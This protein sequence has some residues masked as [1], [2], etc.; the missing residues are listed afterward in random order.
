MTRRFVI[1]IAAFT[2]LG[3]TAVM[4]A[5]LH[6]APVLVHADA[7]GR[8]VKPPIVS[9]Q[10]PFGAKRKDEM[11]AYSKRHYGTRTWHL[12]DPQVIVEHYTDGTTLS[13]AW[14]T[15]AANS[16]HNGELPGTCAHF[17][18]DT[19]GTIYQLVQ[20]DVRCRHAIGMNWTAI[21][22]EHVGT[23]DRMVLGNHA[24]M[25]SSLRLTLWL[26]RRY[27][28]NVGNVIGHAETLE[29]PYHRERYASWR[30][31]THADFP[32]RAMHDYRSRVRALAG[33]RDIPVG[34]GPRWVDNGC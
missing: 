3:V 15:F 14:N 25:R 6:A 28:I 10:I 9:K 8:I 29:S 16:R 1:A 26:M 33:R 30:C 4:P 23:S 27:D 31:M 5:E 34:K 32:H 11:A 7:T 2:A 22:I 20:L 19:D 12:I 18:I 13:G 21:G 17:I 24:Q